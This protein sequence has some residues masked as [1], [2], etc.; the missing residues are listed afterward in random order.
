MVP[1]V[2][3]LDFKYKEGES[4][5]SYVRTA[6]DILLN[7]E[8]CIKRFEGANEA[9]LETNGDDMLQA[10]LARERAFASTERVSDDLQ[11]KIF[12]NLQSMVF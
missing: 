12:A 2:G 4:L 1:T 7:P 9:Q 5:D 10:S 3:E 11:E 6:N 8:G